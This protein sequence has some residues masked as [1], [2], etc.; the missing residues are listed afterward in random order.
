LFWLS[1]DYGLALGL[2]KLLKVGVRLLG[3]P[4]AVD[5]LRRFLE[6]CNFSFVLF[7]FWLWSFW[8]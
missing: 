2:L 4:F 7:I 8:I 3:L 6:F 1:V 5:N